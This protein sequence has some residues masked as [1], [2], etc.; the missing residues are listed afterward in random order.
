[1]YLRLQNYVLLLLIAVFV[2]ST[3]CS[4]D[5]DDAMLTAPSASVVATTV[6]AEP[7]TLNPEFA[8][9]PMCVGG[10]SFGLRLVI[11][12]GSG[13]DV[14]VRR[15]RISLLDRRG[16]PATPISISPLSASVA[17]AL[18]SSVPVVTPGALTM[19]SSSPIAVPS[20]GATSFPLF[21]EFG[22]GVP[23][24]GTLVATVEMTNDK[25]ESETSEMS[26]RVG[27]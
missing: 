18:P 7:A 25:G 24:E 1:M 23:P 6:T 2:I 21:L 19:P 5:N 4:N 10:P 11:T 14:I 12:V 17:G 15:L 3:A 8:V 9:R 20:G 22:C 13:R 26:I 27:R 16:T